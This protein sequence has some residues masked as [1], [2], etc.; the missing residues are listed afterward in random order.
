[1]ITDAWS[2]HFSPL[3]GK[4]V[5]SKQKQGEGEKAQSYE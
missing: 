4:M 1:M 2:R 5:N 3:I